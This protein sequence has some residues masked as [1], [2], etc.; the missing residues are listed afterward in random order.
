MTDHTLSQHVFLQ[1]FLLIQKL[2]LRD[3][4]S[5]SK[6]VLTQARPLNH[7]F[8]LFEDARITENQRKSHYQHS[9]LV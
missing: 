8:G 1:H 6:S 4:V 5:E 2:G 7:S 9:T 3:T